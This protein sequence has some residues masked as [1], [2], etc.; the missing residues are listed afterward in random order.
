MAPDIRNERTEQAIAGA[1][2][3]ELASKSF[4]DITVSSVAQGA[5]VSRSTFYAHFSNTRDVFDRVLAEFVENV[6]DLNVQLRCAACGDDSP[7]VEAKL[8]FC[9]ALRSA[10][11]YGALVRSPEFLPA[12]LDLVDNLPRNDVVEELVNAG[13]Q[14]D[15]ARN[16]MRFQLSGCYA[17]AMSAPADCDWGLSQA[18]LDTYIGGGINTLKR[19]S[20]HNNKQLMSL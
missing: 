16:V 13:V 8:P 1:F 11:R 18:A 17:V 2:L 6:R 20:R 15:I 19:A 5:D 3:E 12:Y 7:D 4:A 9:I 14:P 10:G